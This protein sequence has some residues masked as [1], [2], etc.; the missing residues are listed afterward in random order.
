MSLNSDEDMLY[1]CR[2][3]AASKRGVS[4]ELDKL[5]PLGLDVGTLKEEVGSVFPIAKT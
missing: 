3:W 2:A 4:Y 1:Q 5:G